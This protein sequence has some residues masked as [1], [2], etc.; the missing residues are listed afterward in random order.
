MTFFLVLFNLIM[1]ILFS[2]SWVS[3]KFTAQYSK[4]TGVHVLL[5]MC[6]YLN[7]NT[8]YIFSKNKGLVTMP[9][10]YSESL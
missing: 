6:H 10:Y 2:L 5:K 8:D 1:S 3:S 7:S 9:I 4:G